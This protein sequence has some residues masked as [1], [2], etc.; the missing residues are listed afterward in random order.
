MLVGSR[1]AAPQ[2]WSQVY[3]AL[4]HGFAKNACK[5]IR[6]LGFSDDIMQC[7]DAFTRLQEM[8]HTADYDPDERYSLVDALFADWLAEDALTAL[9]SASRSERRAFS[10]QLLLK[11][12]VP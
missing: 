9:R 5:Q 7:A 4:E 3:R 8:R 2:A 12:R 6:A 1:A 10:V 11:K